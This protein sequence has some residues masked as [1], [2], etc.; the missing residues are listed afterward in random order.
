VKPLPFIRHRLLGISDKPLD[1]WKDKDYAHYV[2]LCACL[3]IACIVGAGGAVFV[4][5]PALLI[6]AMLA[7][8]VMIFQI[9]F[10]ILAW[11][12]HRAKQRRPPPRP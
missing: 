7:A 2:I 11:R 9:V 5:R 3:L 4:D 6:V 10:S 1:D 8:T 12:I